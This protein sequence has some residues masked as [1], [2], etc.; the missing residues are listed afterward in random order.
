MATPTLP[1]PLMRF[2]VFEVDLQV[3]ELR[4]RGHRVKLQEQPFRVLAMLL[5][6][7]G[8]VV[9]REELRQKL[10]PADTFVDFDHGLNSAV[11]RLREALEDSADEPQFVET[12]PRQGYR[13]IGHIDIGAPSDQTKTPE[14]QK[15]E[16]TRS[17]SRNRFLASLASVAL[18]LSIGLWWLI[19]SRANPSLASVELTP[20]A[21]M[22]GYEM[23]RLFPLTV[24]RWHSSKLMDR[25]QEFTQRWWA[26]KNLCA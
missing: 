9:T 6:R 24:A 19:R 5:D 12:V 20:L 7:P 26:A 17:V 10:W 2:E 11:A 4:K 14:A 18:L 16:S 22:P 1:R 3:A 13:F 21:G 8:E 25:I 23:A 15:A